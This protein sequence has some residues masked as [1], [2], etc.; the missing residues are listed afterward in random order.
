[1]SQKKQRICPV[2]LSGSL[3]NRFRRILQNPLKILRPYIC[4][5]MTVLDIGCGPG[6]FTIDMARLVGKSGRVIA[7]D[8]Q[9]GMLKRLEKKI[10]GTELEERVK[11]QLCKEGRLD[12]KYKVD[13]ALAF[14]MVHEIEVKEVFFKEVFLIPLKKE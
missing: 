7:V 5:G 10:R 6:F 9:S 13:F 12:L 8:L 2:H 4:E 3:D 1:M 14:Y 11:L